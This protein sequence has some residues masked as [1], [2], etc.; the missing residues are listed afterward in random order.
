LERAT[1]V[2]T[3]GFVWDAMLRTYQAVGGLARTW[4]DARRPPQRGAWQRGGGARVPVLPEGHAPRA[5]VVIVCRDQI[6]DLDR[7]LAAFHA[8]LVYA[9][10]DDLDARYMVAFDDYELIVVDDASGDGSADC[11]RR[12]V[13]EGWISKAILG[14]RRRG[15]AACVNLGFAHASPGSFACVTLG[16]DVV[17]AT[18]GWLPRMIA[19]LARHPDVGGLSMTDAPRALL[20]A[21]AGTMI[22]YDEPVL[23][24]AA[25]P[26]AGVGLAV[27]HRVL[28][29]VGPFAE[30][31][32]AGLENVDYVSRLV[33]AGLGAHCL[34]G[35]RASRRRHRAGAAPAHG[36]QRPAGEDTILTPEPSPARPR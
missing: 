22:D 30:D 26:S 5:S 4:V 16:A 14:G 1:T 35:L 10:H 6:D 12:A 13:A 20:A 36:R 8:T 32:G 23:D 31:A 24:A 17:P 19:V 33:R 29:Q 25:W 27:P 21:F 11:L 34:A 3:P 15:G 9:D 7:A 2:T 28:A 18:P